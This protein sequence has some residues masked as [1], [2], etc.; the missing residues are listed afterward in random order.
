MASC[1]CL[2]QLGKDCESIRRWLFA[3]SECFFIKGDYAIIAALFD[4]NK[5]T[6]R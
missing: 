2:G 3:K 6:H 1:Y 5:I 4:L